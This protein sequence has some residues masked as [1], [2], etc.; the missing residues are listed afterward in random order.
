M[1]ECEFVQQPFATACHDRFNRYMVECEFFHIYSTSVS[2]I[3]L[4][5][6]WWNVNYLQ[7]SKCKGD[8]VF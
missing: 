6:T 5:D 2:V 8:Y 7:K 3:V 4:I 1:V